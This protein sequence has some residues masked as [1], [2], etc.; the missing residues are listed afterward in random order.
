MPSLTFGYSTL[1]DRLENIQLP[2]LK[3]HPDWDVLITVQ[4][5]NDQPPTAEQL[6]KAPQGERIQVLA[7]AGTGVTKIRN[8]VLANA[9][10][11]YLIFADDDITFNLDGIQKW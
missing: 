4:S 11:D 8:Q 1:A 5:G 3:D 9:K 6:A 7:F 10:G 2:N